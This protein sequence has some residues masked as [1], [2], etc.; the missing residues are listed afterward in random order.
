MT[1]T[2]SGIIQSDGFCQVQPNRFDFGRLV[3]PLMPPSWS[4]VVKK[5]MI[6]DDIAS[7]SRMRYSTDSFSAGS[8][9]SAPTMN[10]TSGA[11]QRRRRRCSSPGPAAGSR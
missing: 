9:T 6:T 3:S 10:A 7:V 8:A 5:P 2:T 4:N 11:Q 1:A